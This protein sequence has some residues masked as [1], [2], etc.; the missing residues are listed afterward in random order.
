MSFDSLLHRLIS[1]FPDMRPFQIDN[2]FA[3][4]TNSEGLGSPFQPETY[5][6]HNVVPEP[7]NES[8]FE[9]YLSHPINQESPW[10]LDENGSTIS[11]PLAKRPV[12]EP[13]SKTPTPNY[14]HQSQGYLNS[15][16][17]LRSATSLTN[18]SSNSSRVS[19]KIIKP[20]VATVFWEEENSICYQVKANGIVVSRKG[21]D[22]FVNGTKLLNVTGMSRGRRDGILKV[23]KGRRV[24]RNGSMNLKG[25]WIP[26]D[27]AL[28]LARNE[29]IKD[30]LYPLFVDD[31]N[32][33][34]KEKGNRLR[35]ELDDD[36][37]SLE[38]LQ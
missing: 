19:R 29:G 30:L 14:D 1:K 26:Y 5:D 12:D 25:V 17:S 18:V 28:E 13:L 23:E 11:T 27:R 2:S 22:N 9:N 3:P 6:F 21:S 38:P 16:S 35:E 37:I 20:L 34:Y 7:Y 31:I 4:P 10:T 36:A 15:V 33:H 8:Y 32:K 24:I